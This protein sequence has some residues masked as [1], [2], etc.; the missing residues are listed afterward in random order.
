MKRIVIT[1]VAVVF[2][3]VAAQAQSVRAE[4]AIINTGFSAFAPKANTSDK[5]EKASAKQSTLQN[6]VTRQVARARATATKQQADTAKQQAPKPAA[7]PAAKKNNGKAKTT[8]G[9]VGTWLKAI[10]LGGPFPGE[11]SDE[12]HNRLAAQSQPAA[13]PYK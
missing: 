6:N 4:V 10:F 13:L 2:A 5:K 9:S 8:E 3:A 11:T 7:K 12:Y 1:L